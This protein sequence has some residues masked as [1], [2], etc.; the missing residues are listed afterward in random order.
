MLL[1]FLLKER[2]MSEAKI[3]NATKS[4]TKTSVPANSIRYKIVT[5]LSG[6]NEVYEATAEI[7]GFKATKVTRQ[8]GT[9]AFT[10]RSALTKACKDRAAS[11][12]RIPIFDLGSATVA[13]SKKAKAPKAGKVVTF[14]STG[15]P[16]TGACS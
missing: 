13:P 11:L 3:K 2:Q 10:T 15:C 4:T 1:S 14:C 9:T 7:S 8:D 12:K 6:V 16:V 5:K